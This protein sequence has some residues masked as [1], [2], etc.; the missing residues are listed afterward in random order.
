MHLL[1]INKKKKMKKN[2]DVVH[3]DSNACA[4]NYSYFIWVEGSIWY[5]I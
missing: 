5:I 3:F 1:W 2:I 4:N